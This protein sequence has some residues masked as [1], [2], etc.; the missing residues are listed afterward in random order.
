MIIDLT[1]SHQEP[2]FDFEV[3]WKLSPSEK[4]DWEA[5]HEW[6]EFRDQHVKDSQ[7]R[8]EAITAVR[9]ALLDGHMRNILM[10]A[11]CVQIRPQVAKIVSDLD[12]AL[13]LISFNAVAAHIVDLDVEE[14]KRRKESGYD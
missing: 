12:H 2:S 8:T 3:S 11:S 7:S 5:Y 14:G 1:G 6:I 4:F 13:R 10:R 9:A